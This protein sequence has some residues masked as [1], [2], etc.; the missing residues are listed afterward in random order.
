MG[1]G[2]ASGTFD[3]AT[4][5]YTSISLASQYVNII[6]AENLHY[7]VIRS[8]GGAASTYGGFLMLVYHVGFLLSVSVSVFVRTSDGVCNTG[9]LWGAPLIIMFPLSAETA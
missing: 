6:Q 8:S 5:W 9:E 1:G 3:F 2:G 4:L 7:T